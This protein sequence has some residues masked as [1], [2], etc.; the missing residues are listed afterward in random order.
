MLISS[1][2]VSLTVTAPLQNR[3]DTEAALT[4]FPSDFRKYAIWEQRDF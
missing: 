1:P 3:P 4:T 2:L